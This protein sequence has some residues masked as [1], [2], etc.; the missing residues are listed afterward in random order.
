[1]GGGLF[2]QLDP[3]SQDKTKPKRFPVSVIEFKNKFDMN[4]CIRYMRETAVNGREGVPFKVSIW[5]TT[6]YVKPEQRWLLENTQ[7]RRVGLRS[8]SPARLRTCSTC[9][10]EFWH[11]APDHAGPISR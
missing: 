7:P 10:Y 4:K 5:E 3:D 6:E 1:M 2:E 9:D 8:T 11:V